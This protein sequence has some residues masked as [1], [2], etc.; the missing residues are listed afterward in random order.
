V[1]RAELCG[2]DGS[3]TRVALHRLRPDTA[4]GVATTFTRKA[5]LAAQLQ[6]PNIARVYNHG[7]I[8]GTHYVAMEL[9]AGRSLHRAALGVPQVLDVLVQLCGALDHLHRPGIPPG[10]PRFAA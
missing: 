4:P 8:E 6:H 10:P 7:R 2:L 3:R 9:V 1:H 5:K